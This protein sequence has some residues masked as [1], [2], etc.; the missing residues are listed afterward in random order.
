MAYAFSYKE[1]LYDYVEKIN[2]SKMV[3]KDKLS[4]KFGEEIDI[5]K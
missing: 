3:D 4:C 5:K 1:I 2:K